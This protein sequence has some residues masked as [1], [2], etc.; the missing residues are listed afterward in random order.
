MYTFSF[1]VGNIIPKSVRC[2]HS[3]TTISIIV[4]N[5][6]VLETLILFNSTAKQ[7][8]INIMLLS[9]LLPPANPVTP[10]P[11]PEGRRH[12]KIIKEEYSAGT[13]L[14]KFPS[15]GLYCRKYALE[16]MQKK[17]RRTRGPPP[18]NAKIQTSQ[19]KIENTQKINPQ[20][21]RIV[22]PCRSQFKDVPGP[23]L[24]ET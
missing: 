5:T 6:C 10:P 22:S 20:G 15:A 13:C 14:S 17:R 1:I 4:M 24:V 11:C 7:T 19:P 16:T 8:I 2:V 21:S 12:P 9:C 18:I 23:C 3:A